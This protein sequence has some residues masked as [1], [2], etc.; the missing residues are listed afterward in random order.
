MSSNLIPFPLSGTV[1]ARST[2]GIASLVLATTLTSC[3]F[4][5]GELEPVGEESAAPAESTPSAEPDTAEQDGESTAAEDVIEEHSEAEDAQN[6]LPMAASEALTWDS[7]TYWLSGTGEA[8][9]RLD[10]TPSSDMTLDLTHSGSSNF[11]IVTYGADETRYAS[12]VNEIGAYEGSVTLGDL[13]LLDGAEAVDYLHIQ[14]DGAWT[15][16]R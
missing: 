11:I 13:P 8:L 12:L 4:A 15:I 9:Y 3:S 16:A 6:V 10:W 1:L 5:L 7:E 2:A 14:A